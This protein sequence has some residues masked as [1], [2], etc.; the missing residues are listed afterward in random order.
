MEHILLSHISKHV[1][2]NNILVDDQ[3][4]F[5]QKL[6]T[7]TQLISITQD[8]SHTLQCRGQTYFVFLDFQ[9]AFDRVLYRHLQAKLEYYGIIGDTSHYIM[10]LLSKRQQLVVKGSRSF[11]M[12]VTF[13]GTSRFGDRIRIFLSL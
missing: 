1:A 4:G 6:S 8:W 7:T 2:T 9:E 5:R 12:A 3:H 13:G 10:S 11:W